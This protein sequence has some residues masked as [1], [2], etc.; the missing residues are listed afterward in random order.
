MNINLHNYETFFLLYIDNELS[1]AEKNDVEEFVRQYPRLQQEL[2]DLKESVLPLDEIIFAHKPSLHKTESINEPMQEKLLLH[3]DNELAGQEKEQLEILLQT[4]T[5]LQ[6][7]WS[8]LQKTTLDAAEIIS[9]PG[10]AILYRH[11]KARLITGS[12]MRWA[13]AAALLAAGFFVGISLLKNQR[14]S[15]PVIANN[16]DKK[17]GIIQPDNKNRGLVKEN[18]GKQENDK[19]EI[20]TQHQASKDFIVQDK[21][22]TGKRPIN[23]EVKN[24][25]PGKQP[26]DFANNNP[27]SLHNKETVSTNENV[28]A[29][30]TTQLPANNM[31]II[32]K[33]VIKEAGNLTA[34]N[35]PKQKPAV[36]LT[37]K[38]IL[39]LQ[40]SYAKNASLGFKEEN[41]N[42]IFMMDEQN[43]SRSKAAGFFKKLKRTVERTTKIKS[44]NSLKIAGFEFAVK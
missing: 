34:I 18:P 15:L 6:A 12:F 37:D 24:N 27:T 9:F 5:A 25:H 19:K 16:N 8:L 30:T 28:V 20:A 13:V 26:L 7:E 14:S 22:I 17:P 2:N 40:N 36:E 35:I 39:P 42:H 44:G 11:E 43:I 21:T 1:V 38:D 4:N 3:L 10:K 31:N 23:K 32:E 41:D 29:K 33:P